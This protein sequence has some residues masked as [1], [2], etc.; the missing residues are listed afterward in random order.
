[1][2][3]VALVVVAGFAVLALLRVLEAR[4]GLVE[5]EVC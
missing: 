4:L 3:E 1:M 5:V 2:A